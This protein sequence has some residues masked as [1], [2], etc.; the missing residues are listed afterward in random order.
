MD[1]NLVKLYPHPIGVGAIGIHAALHRGAAGDASDGDGGVV[2][3]LGA[4]VVLAAR[5]GAWTGFTWPE[6]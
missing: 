1:A 6:P 2:E 5:K 4:E 3:V